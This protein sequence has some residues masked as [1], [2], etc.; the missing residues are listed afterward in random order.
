MT[1]PLFTIIRNN[2]PQ[3]CWLQPWVQGLK[4]QLWPVTLRRLLLEREARLLLLHRAIEI[5]W[6]GRGGSNSHPSA[7]E[8]DALIP[9][10]YHP[11]LKLESEVGIGPTFAVLQTD[12][13]SSI[14]NSPIE[15]AR[16]GRLEHPSW[17]LETQ[18]Q[19]LYHHRIE[20]ACW[21]A[22]CLQVQFAKRTHHLFTSYHLYPN[23]AYVFLSGWKNEP[24]RKS[25]W[26]VSVPLTFA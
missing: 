6:W 10:S 3:I 13:Y 22:T 20:I 12:A 24:L 9:L 17:V 5:V 16:W 7:S 2:H 19:P 4:W 21:L 1:P 23:L 26:R 11:I 18:A 25:K 8:S 14:D 15:M